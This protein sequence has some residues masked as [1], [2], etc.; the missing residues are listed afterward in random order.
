MRDS[1]FAD[2]AGSMRE[3]EPPLFSLSVGEGMSKAFRLAGRSF[4]VAAF[5]LPDSLSRRRF[6]NCLESRR[7]SATTEEVCFLFC[8]SS[9]QSFEGDRASSPV[10]AGISFGRSSLYVISYIVSYYMFNVEHECCYNACLRK[11]CSTEREKISL[12]LPLRAKHPNLNLRRFS[13][14]I[15][16]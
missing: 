16:I 5:P 2:S 10:T 11:Y 15:L 1:L 3:F 6:S 8:A 7:L 12:I 4:G 14:I 13:I 9:L